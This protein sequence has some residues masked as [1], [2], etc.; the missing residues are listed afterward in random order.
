MALFK[1]C[2][3]NPVHLVLDSRQR[4]SKQTVRMQWKPFQHVLCFQ[5]VDLDQD[6]GRKISISV[7]KKRQ[8]L[9]VF[10]SDRPIYSW[11]FQNVNINDQGCRPMPYYYCG[12]PGSPCS[13]FKDRD[14][15][16]SIEEDHLHQSMHVW[17]K[18]KVE[19]KKDPVPVRRNGYGV[20]LEQRQ[21]WTATNGHNKNRLIIDFR[22]DLGQRI[23]K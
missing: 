22:F 19:K 20:K 2:R 18:W 5:R 11:L 1:R 14:L 17:W 21:L 12:A 13:F 7:M 3:V 4:Q 16:Q 23:V 8:M 9:S 10:T 6:L 15:F